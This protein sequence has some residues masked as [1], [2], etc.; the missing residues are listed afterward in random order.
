MNPEEIIHKSWNPIRHLLNQEALRNL[1]EKVLPN[2][3]Y[4]PSYKQDI[5]RVFEMPVHTIKVVVVG[6]EP[7]SLPKDS[8]GYAFALSPTAITKKKP[9]A[10]GNIER[11]LYDDLG[12]LPEDVDLFK[13]TEQG[14]FLLNMALTV[15]T[16]TNGSHLEYWK[17]FIQEVVAFIAR[18]NPCVWLL[19]GQMAQSLI[20][21]IRNNTF[22]V[23]G[24]DSK[25]IKL[26]PAS[27]DYNYILTAK[28]PVSEEFSGCKHF[29]MTNTILKKNHLI[30]I[31]W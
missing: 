3:S 11:E 23:K 27:P 9:I 13:W 25:T 7:Y 15:E 26:I 20:P 21:C 24:Y 5:F 4:Q 8:D 18:K 28:Q 1:K 30:K 2:I 12:I 6:Q 16:A 17:K 31:N 29:S 10:I 14:V 22:H 19:W